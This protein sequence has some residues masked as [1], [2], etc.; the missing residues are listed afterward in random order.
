MCC[1][2]SRR[3][4]CLVLCRVKRKPMLMCAIH[5]I[6]SLSVWLA[7]RKVRFIRSCKGG[8]QVCWV[9]SARH[10]TYSACVTEQDLLTRDL[11]ACQLAVTWSVLNAVLA[12]CNTGVDSSFTFQS[13]ESDQST[14]GVQCALVQGSPSARG[15]QHRRCSHICSA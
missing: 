15:P 10:A 2:K 1:S 9:M 8:K 14:T 7:Y 12:S 3:A 6:R 11:H 13:G 4:F 5:M